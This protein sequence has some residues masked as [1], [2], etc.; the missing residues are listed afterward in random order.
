MKHVY[1]VLKKH[2]HRSFPGIST[3]AILTLPALSFDRKPVKLSQPNKKQGTSVT[4]RKMVK[5]YGKK[6]ASLFG[7]VVRAFL[8]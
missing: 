4:R 3:T 5:R 6:I 1:K 7:N 2:K 8:T